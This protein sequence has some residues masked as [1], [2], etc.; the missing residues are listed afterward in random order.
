MMKKTV[1]LSITKKYLLDLLKPDA[2]FFWVVIVY[3][4]VISL[5][6]LAVPIAVQTLINT[7]ANIAS[8]RALAILAFLLFFT[9]A[10][11]GIFSVLRLH[12]L[13]YYSRKIYAR[14]TTD[15]GLHTLFSSRRFFEGHKNISI[16]HYYYEITT[17]Q[18]NLPTL[19]IDGFA[20]ILQM[21]VGIILVSFYHPS[22]LV[23]NMILL[24]SLYFAWRIWS[25][26]G[27][28]TAIALSQA[29]YASGKWLN[30]M[31]MVHHFFSSTSRIDYAKKVTDRTITEYIDKH[32]EYYFFTFYQHAM[33]L[34][35]FAV[36]S[37]ALLGLGG[38][39][40]IQGEMSIGQLV[41]AELIMSAIFF[42]LSRFARF[43]ELYYELYG[44]ADKIAMAISSP[45]ERS[46][47]QNKPLPETSNI[48][49]N[50]VLLKHGEDHCFINLKL[51]AGG[52]YYLPSWLQQELVTLL[53][54]TEPPKNGWV[55]IGDLALSDYDIF[56]LREAIIIID[57]SLIME[58]SI[59]DFLLLATPGAS[60]QELLQVIDAVEILHVIDD[61]PEKLDTV[62]TL[63]GYPLKKLD[64]LLLKVAG[65]L[66]SHPKVL[67]VGRQFNPL[68]HALRGRLFEMLSEKLATILYFSDTA[69]LP[70][71]DGVLR[72]EAE[73]NHIIMKSH[74]TQPEEERNS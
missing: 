4:I 53:T 46:G 34:F 61:L 63:S 65:A 27:K 68:N 29:K 10:L 6:T 26:G 2:N 72:L 55:S 22:L 69:D 20:L 39:L 8:G 25:S 67:I 40:V 23:F 64:F 48:S 49:F 37:A 7:I 57:D 11:Y 56:A 54:Y 62:L 42:G 38:W 33:F 41:A 21:L 74:L 3:S 35:I 13:E 59:R 24:L 51:K 9:L 12:I 70:N 16:T 17:L 58:C 19:L 66:L 31:A 5:L 45:Q 30:E 60:D 14:L 1:D 52:K 36:A 15:I 73:S 50:G 71:F 43:L 44:A 32:T 47:E 18:K 28:R